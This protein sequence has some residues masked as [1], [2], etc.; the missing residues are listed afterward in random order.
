[1]L[2]WHYSG[3]RSHPTEKSVQ[4]LRPLIRTFSQ[5]GEVVLDPF[6]G[7][8][9]TSIAAALE[10]RR[11]FGIEL[12]AEYFRLSQ[13]RM[14]GVRPAR[15]AAPAAASAPAPAAAPS[16]DRDFAN[17]GRWLQDRGFT[18]DNRWLSQHGSSP[19]SGR[20]GWRATQLSGRMKRERRN[21]SHRAV[22]REI[23]DLTCGGPR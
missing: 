11:F 17:F 10:G 22:T 20:R 16:F 6:S 23:N 3:N 2:P 12:D 7:S 8:G 13:Q 9:S 21:L 18:V 5:P 1:V 19:A 14:A 15:P 4:I